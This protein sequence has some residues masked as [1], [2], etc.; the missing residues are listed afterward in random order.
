[1]TISQLVAL[2]FVLLGAMALVVYGFRYRRKLA[3]TW[4]GRAAT[5]L[6]R[7]YA[8]F[9]STSDEVGRAAEEGILVHV[10]LGKGS[11]MEENAMTSVAALQGLNAMLNLAASYNI[12]PL[13]TTADPTL[14]L[15]AADWVRRAYIQQGNL[16]HYRPISVQF[17]AASSALYAA[18]A[19]TYLFDGGIGAN[20]AL[21]SF[22][23][24]ISLLA[25]A[26][27]RR[28]IYMAGGTVSPQSL[29]ALYPA[30]PPQQLLMGEELF[31]GGA[32][33]SEQSI[34]RASLWSQDI[35]RLIVIISIIL[36][37]ILS[38][39]GIVPLG[40]YSG[41]GGVTP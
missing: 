17:T 24:E 19:A 25:E 32:S 37:S 29:G 6:R 39:L 9:K 20:F 23:Q 7:A 36:L 22:D 1:M 5:S 34:Y 18:M 35:L 28:G 10:A 31:A 15:L 40:N 11:I 21:G 30:L 12:P 41:Y 14:Y 4:K 2:I 26:G 16:R 3:S 38:F 27:R 8:V 33:V 13:I